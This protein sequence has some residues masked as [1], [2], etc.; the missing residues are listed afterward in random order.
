MDCPLYL[1]AV[2]AIGVF[3]WPLRGVD[4]RQFNANCLS[5]GQLRSIEQRSQFSP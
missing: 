4:C 3:I 2:G 5:S 1:A